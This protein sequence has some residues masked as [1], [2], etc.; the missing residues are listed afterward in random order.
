VV[1]ISDF[2]PHDDALRRMASSELLLLVIEPF[3]QAK[4]MITSKLYE[5][6]ASER[7]VLGVGPPSGDANALLARHDAG[8]VVA[9]N[10][11]RRARE[12]LKTHY[13]AWAAGTPRPGATRASLTD[14]TR[15]NQ[16]RR[17]AEVLEAVRVE[18]RG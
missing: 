5:Y 16:A 15:R 12:I 17:M 9:W 1:E 4:G 7:P 6:L 11:A 10:D 18:S 3:A 8:E 13:D 2:V 14:H